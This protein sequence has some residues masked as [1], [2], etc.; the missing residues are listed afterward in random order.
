[1][2][3]QRKELLL[4]VM[5]LAVGL[6]QGG[7]GGVAGR[8]DIG[9]IST[10]SASPPVAGDAKGESEQIAQVRRL[11]RSACKNLMDIVAWK[12][13]APAPEP[14]RR[15]LKIVRPRRTDANKGELLRDAAA[16]TGCARYAWNE[17]LNGLANG[18]GGH[19]TQPEWRPTIDA[20]GAAMDEMASAIEA[21]EPARAMAACGK[22]CGAFVKLVGLLDSSRTS[23]RL[24][25][26]RKAAKPLFEKV[27]AGDSESLRKAADD[28]RRLRD[29]AL[30]NPSGGTGTEGEK[31]QALARFSA[32]VNG[33]VEA[34]Q[35]TG[36]G[37]LA[38]KY[39]EMIQALEAA[40]DLF[41]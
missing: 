36:T 4:K 41:L 10:V 39:A 26:F 19:A 27:E 17:Y 12:P 2:Y 29:E 28:L 7:C 18:S 32:A 34:V 15:Y 8:S 35:Q 20:I 23:E 38:D 21:G 25:A 33:F 30:E 5:C 40:Y 6:M 16:G 14:T 13:D 9:A 31:H 1:M 37:T 3:G 24:F 11:L 22:G